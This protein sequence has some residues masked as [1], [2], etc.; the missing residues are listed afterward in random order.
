MRPNDR[1]NT[2]REDRQSA[3]GRRDSDSTVTGC[4]VRAPG[5]DGAASRDGRG[6]WTSGDDRQRFLALVEV[7]A[8]EDVPGLGACW[9]WQGRRT[10]DGYPLIDIGGRPVRAHRWAW[11][12]HFGLALPATWT[13]D[14]VCHTY[15]TT[16]PGGIGCW[17]TR[18]VRPNHLE[19]LPPGGNVARRHARDRALR[20][21][22]E[23]KP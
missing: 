10:P 19:P 13:L 16:C 2:E 14:H 17:H 12:E 15:S 18:C 5:S 3:S 8:V 1:I 23:M 6:R 22:K 7:Q 20:A 4:P 9:L 11:S 21:I